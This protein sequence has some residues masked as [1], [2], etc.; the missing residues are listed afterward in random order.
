MPNFKK[1]NF[2]KKAMSLQKNY[3]PLYANDVKLSIT[4]RTQA[5]K[6]INN[7]SFK[8][9][10]KEY[11]KKKGS[12]RVNLTDTGQ[13]LNSIDWKKI[14]YGV[15][16]YFNSTEQRNKAKGNQ[17]K[18]KFFGIDPTARQ[19]LQKQLQKIYHKALKD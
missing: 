19:R 15:R 8:K 1:P 14:P 5:G 16:M 9:Y 3:L 10:S 13:M 7:K 6:D 12:V 4:K 11:A 17:N 18:R 2:R